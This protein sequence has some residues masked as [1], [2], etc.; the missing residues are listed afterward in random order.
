MKKT[1]FTIL[2]FSLLLVGCGRKVEN[3]VVSGDEQAP[4]TVVENK[5]GLANPAS[6]NCE[7]QGGKLE[8]KDKTN[9]QYGICYF[10][11]NRQCEEWALFRGEC[12]EGG[13]KITGYENDA[14]IFCAIT[15]GQ[16]DIQKNIC[17]TARGEQCDIDAYYNGGCEKDNSIA[18]LKVYRDNKN[19]F[20]FQYP[21][22]YHLDETN[23]KRLVSGDA[24]EII[25]YAPDLGRG[26]EG[27]KIIE[28]SKIK[29][30]NSNNFFNKKVY[31]WEEN[32]DF[33]EKPKDFYQSIYIG[34]NVEDKTGSIEFS[35]KNKDD[36]VFK[37]IDVIT[38]SFKFTN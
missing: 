21:S 29:M 31:V 32:S 6:A 14:Q 17:T 9:G 13:L 36:K 16:V 15:G 28:T 11:D 26:A 37:A 2:V 35:S 24:S 4:S 34:W 38:R 27:L 22:T 10:E 19:G 23:G 30:G 3:I 5:A 20:E 12:P 25:I 1:I 8:I 7:A 33:G 18:D